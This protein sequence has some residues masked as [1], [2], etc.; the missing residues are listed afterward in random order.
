M[1]YHHFSIEEREIIQQMWWERKPLRAIAKETGRSVSS[2]SRELKR[3]FPPERQVYTP[4]LA[5]ERALQHR[6][7]RG[8]TQRLKSDQIRDYVVS[9]LKR[10]WSPEQIA[11]RM[12]TELSLSISH[13]AIYQFIYAQISSS[14]LRRGSEDLRCYLR[15][16]RKIRLPHGAR[17]G[18]RIFKPQGK[19]IELRPLMVA[20]RA[21]IGDWEGDTVE[22]VNHK[23]GI[24]TLVERKLGLVFITK[25]LNKTSAATIR[26]MTDRF[27]HVPKQFKQ[28]VTLD[29]GPENRDSEAIE[30][31]TGLDCFLAHP[32]SAWERPTNENTNGLI[33]DYF[34][35]KTDFSMI[36]ND[37]VRFVENELNSRPRKRLGW[38]TPLEAWSVALQS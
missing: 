8:R 30:K 16:R 11:G 29:N 7:H 17:K 21:R 10:R 4:R 31:A 36:T 38:Q 35:K 2:I 27:H 37:E 20:T 1:K 3:N 5:H 14:Y 24:N 33:R 28:T 32:Y 18:Q 26:A 15:R 13:E 9:H 23:P 12:K 6:R 34:P 25:L 22:S 19:S